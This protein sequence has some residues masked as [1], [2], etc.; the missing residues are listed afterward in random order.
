MDN[1][2]VSIKCAAELLGISQQMLRIG[3]QQNAFPFGVA[4]KIKD[5]SK[6][7]YYINRNQLNQYLNRK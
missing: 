2:N 4:I 3:L 6:Y 5:S 1:P 7:T